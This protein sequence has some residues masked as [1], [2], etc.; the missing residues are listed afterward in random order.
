MSF[1][2]EKLDVQVLSYF[3]LKS[4]KSANSKPMEKNNKD[5]SQQ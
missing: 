1:F 4:K 2:R 3:K 5:Y